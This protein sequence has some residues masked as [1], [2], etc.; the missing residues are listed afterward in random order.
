MI[1]AWADAHHERTGTWP[2]ARS[3]LVGDAPGESW[4]AIDA[5][6]RHGHRGLP[7]GLSLSWLLAQNGREGWAKPLT[8]ERILAWAD[9]HHARTGRWPT[10]TSGPIPEA[11]G[12]TWRAINAALTRGH[13]SLPG[14]DSLARLLERHRG[15]RPGNRTSWTAAEDE[16]VRSLPPAE[17]AKQTGRNIRA[18]YLRRYTLGVGKPG[19]PGAG[20]A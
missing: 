14:G 15:P 16:A 3:G 5:A 6:L 9:A 12:E 17:A 20:G 8:V 4:Q 13:R 10:D 11:P 18:V 19:R 2:Q 7:E 1:L